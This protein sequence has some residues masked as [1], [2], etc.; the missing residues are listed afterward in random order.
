MLRARQLPGFFVSASGLRRLCPR[1]ARGT[2]WCCN[3][4]SHTDTFS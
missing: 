3:I 4:F 2:L 1:A